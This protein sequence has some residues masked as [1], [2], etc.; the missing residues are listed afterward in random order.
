MRKLE[1]DHSNP[2]GLC[3]GESPQA[4]QALHDYALLGPGRSLT[5]LYRTYTE[6]TP[7]S[8]DLSP[9]PTRQLR[10]LKR[11]SSEDSW[12]E[13]IAR[14]DALLL[15]REREDHER[16]WVKRREAEREETWQLAQEL[17]A[18]AKEM[19]KFPLADVEHVTAQRRGANGV[20]QVDM[21]VIKAAR[22][23][24]R[25]IAALGETAAKLARLSADMP[26]DRLAIEDLTP[27]DLEGMSTEELQLL[28]QQIERQRGRR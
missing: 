17:R 3:A 2:L 12:Q 16:R 25:D 7:G 22:W 24:L 8:T 1:W 19:L 21:T 9:A 13:R 28:K 6:C 11:W 27:R 15:E 4:H 14:Y 26:T 20:Q 5:G 10:T 23:A 18:K